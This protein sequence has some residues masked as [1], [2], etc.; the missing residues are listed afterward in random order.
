MNIQGKLVI[1]G[2]AVDKGSFTETNLDD[3]SSN[4]LNFFEEGILK[5]IIDESKHK[6]QS[7]IEVI[8]TASKI[9]KEIGPEYVK[10]LN[11]LGANNVDILNIERREEAM[12]PVI[13]ARLKA[14]DVV[15]FTGGDQ[16][17]LTS[18]LGGTLFHDLLL[19]K[20]HK[21]DFIYA[22]TSAGAAAASNN[23]IYQG[24]SSE[25]L[26]KGEVK[27]T[28]G[29][30]LIDG[31]II[32]THFVQRGR[33]GR[34]FQSV[35]GNPKVFGIGLGEDTGLL[36]TNG[37]QMEAIGSGLVILVDGR[38]IKDTNLTEIELGQPIS[39]SHLVTHVMSKFD[40]FNLGTFK[41]TIQSSQYV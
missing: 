1:I 27:I 24:S 22:G 34:L 3:N 23:M 18:I 20:Y 33:I 39:I 40:T 30:G 6:T 36:I 38:E 29:L 5:R 14:A 26:L 7:R 15:M 12:D 32:D 28:S 37:K 25:A 16:L 17:R 8:T 35:V 10:A 11:Y 13:V 41:M 9:P 31:V 21:E 4:N 2:G 19:E